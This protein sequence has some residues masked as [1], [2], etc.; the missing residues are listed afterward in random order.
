MG[1]GIAAISYDSAAMLKSF[2]ERKGIDYPLLS[3]PDSK[4]IRAFGILNDNV[5]KDLPQFGIPFPGLYLLNRRGVVTAKYFEDDHR[6]RYTAASVL[7]HEFNQDGTAKTTVETP[8][9]KLSYSASDTT[10]S[11]GGTAALILDIEFKPGMHVYAPGVSSDYIP[12]DWKEP[13][14]KGWIAGPVVYPASKKLR[15]EAI[16]E[17]VPVFE[18]HFRLVRDLTVGQPAETGPLLD[19]NGELAVEGAFKYQ[20]CDAR[21]CYPP[22]SIPLK[23]GFRIEKLDSQRGPAEL[24]RKTP[25][26]GQ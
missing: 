23:W 2:A 12:I 3:D 18:G 13:E 6:E 16:H 21:E 24:Q 15:L 19:A 17:T 20:A 10:L 9:L 1:L 8:H 22:K 14:S 5:P 11:A 25:G 26:G 7:V 4:I